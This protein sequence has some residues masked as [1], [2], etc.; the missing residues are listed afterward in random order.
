VIEMAA[1]LG[2]GH[3]AELCRLATGVDLN[4]LA[5]AAA[6]GESVEKPRPRGRGGACVRFLV[7]PPGQLSEL[8]GLDEA[9]EVE[10]VVEARAYRRAGWVFG[11]LRRGA[12]R[13]G[14]VLAAG[15]SRGDALARADRAAQLVQFVT[16]D[17]E[18][19]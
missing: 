8:R 18:V 3:D 7:A 19:A 15:R 6:L 14:F 17:A 5:L 4:A 16:A 1:R 11:P 12:D 10:G 9:S 2:G 13:A